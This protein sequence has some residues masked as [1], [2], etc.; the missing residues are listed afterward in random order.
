MSIPPFSCGGP[1]G[2]THPQCIATTTGSPCTTLNRGAP[3][4]PPKVVALW[5]KKGP[6][7]SEVC[8]KEYHCGCGV[9]SIWRVWSLAHN[10]RL[11][12]LT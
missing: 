1:V 2:G 12:S 11:Q 7:G 3:E 8:G 5:V 10:G 4:E 9:L 6:V